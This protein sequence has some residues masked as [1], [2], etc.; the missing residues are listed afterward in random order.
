MTRAYAPADLGDLGLRHEVGVFVYRSSPGGLLYLLLHPHPRPEEVWRPVVEPVG[1]DE[2]LEQAAL[3][4]VRQETGLNRAWD[5]VPAGTGLVQHVGDLQLVQWAVGFQV[6]SRRIQLRTRPTVAGSAWRPFE[7]ALRSLA[8]E[9][10][11]QNLLL[12][13]SRL[14]AA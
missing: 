4:G 13:H 6:R 5:L 1:L 3:R 8:T 12:L 7:A 9:L 10:H 14:T 2:D 11:R